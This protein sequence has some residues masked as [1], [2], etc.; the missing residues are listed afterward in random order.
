PWLIIIDQVD[1]GAFPF[2]QVLPP[3]FGTCNTVVVVCRHP[4][5]TDAAA[6]GHRDRPAPT[7]A[8]VPMRP[9]TSRQAAT[10]LGYLLRR[11]HGR[12]RVTRRIPRGFEPHLHNTTPG[13]IQRLSDAYQSNQTHETIAHLQA[14]LDSTQKEGGEARL[15]AI[16]RLTIGHL[17]EAEQRFVV[18]LALCDSDT[19]APMLLAIAERL[20]GEEGPSAQE[21]VRISVTRGY[22]RPTWSRDTPVEARRYHITKLGRGIAR[23]SAAQIG[24]E[25]E[26][27]A[28][29][30]ILDYYRGAANRQRLERVETLPNILG[31]LE[32]AQMPPRT[33]PEEDTLAFTRLLKDVVYYAGSW[34]VGARWLAYGMSIARQ[35]NRPIV[36]GDLAAARAR[37]LLGRGRPVPA[38]RDL[39]EAEAAYTRA[40][41]TAE[42]N[43][44]A[45]VGDEAPLRAMLRYSALQRLWL[46][47][48][49]AVADL[50]SASGFTDSAALERTFAAIAAARTTLRAV[51]VA[52]AG[53]YP[54]L[55]RT[56]E[57]ALALDAAEGEARLG[58][59]LTRQGETHEGARQW[60]HAYALARQTRQAAERHIRGMR[61]RGRFA[62]AARGDAGVSRG[63]LDGLVGAWRTEGMLCHY[64]GLSAPRWRRVLLRRRGVAC[65]R[66][67]LRYAT[68]LS[69]RY[70]QALAL[71]EIAQL[72]V[73]GIR[74]L[75]ERDAP[76]SAGAGGRWP[77]AALARCS[78]HWYRLRTARAQ[79]RLASAFAAVLGAQ[80]VHVRCLVALADYSAR[81]WRIERD[82]GLLAEA[83]EHAAAAR[84]IVERLSEATP[85]LAERLRSLPEWLL[86]TSV[87]VSIA[88]PV[89][90]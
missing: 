50:A 66:Q 18:A 12:T 76:P 41:E 56:I 87:P 83:C 13:I 32:W 26:L 46:A 53:A 35:E 33:L 58:N 80:V 84:A 55:T 5:I 68:Q 70:D 52:S 57:Q 24:A 15:R 10:L 27:R 74:P 59:V 64:R 21:L 78:P 37:I 90:A 22:L 65:L 19:A 16:V 82:P 42:E 25:G 79:V 60:A 54:R 2:E 7:R 4:H 48:L 20:R 1:D 11:K 75:A 8:D 77:R 44:R 49:R 47:H 85:E 14:T 71:Y 40:R 69:S 72:V 6:R 23:A 30:A 34:S 63:A 31:I 29:A 45:G 28:G 39:R 88:M 43:L 9:F 51:A 17:T 3:L 89:S 67:S 38:V 61:N 73:I 81:L 36:L 86:P 62:L